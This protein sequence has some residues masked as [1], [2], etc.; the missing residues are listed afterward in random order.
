[1]SLDRAPI[2]ESK[3][4]AFEPVDGL[5]YLVI[6]DHRESPPGFATAPKA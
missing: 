1:M 4:Q 2:L 6:D 5:N 3:P